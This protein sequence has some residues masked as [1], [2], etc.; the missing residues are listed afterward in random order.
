[1]RASAA[2]P[3]VLAL[4]SAL[5]AC[6]ERDR[7]YGPIRLVPKA[8]ASRDERFLTWGGTVT[9]GGFARPVLSAATPID[10]PVENLR[11]SDGQRTTRVVL[12]AE[13][14]AYPW[15]IIE[16]VVTRD[17]VT[18]M[19]R[20]WPAVGSQGGTA[21]DLPVA[22]AKIG[23]DE[24]P[25][26]VLRAAPDLAARDVETDEVTVPA[27]TVLLFGV[28]LE[29]SSLQVTAIPIDMTVSAL[30]GER[31]IELHTVRLKPG[32]RDVQAWADAQIPLDQIAGRVVRFRFSARP[33]AGPTAVPALPIWADPTIVEAGTIVR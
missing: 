6:G 1:M 25:G 5:G 22:E 32:G 9:I 13:L 28:A 29:P 2:M 23:P 21:F 30:T 24:A 17:G 7:P 3:L 27:H 16:S 19:I 31:V 14:R 15:M 11:S 26:V 18:S 33:I 4:V 20:A 12:P 10:P 8:D